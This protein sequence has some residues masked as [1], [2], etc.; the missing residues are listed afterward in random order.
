MT[1][2]INEKNGDREEIG[3]V[4]FLRTTEQLK[5]YKTPSNITQKLNN[6]LPR[7]RGQ[8]GILCNSKS[9]PLIELKDDDSKDVNSESNSNEPCTFYEALS[10]SNASTG[11]NHEAIISEL[12]APPTI[13][14]LPKILRSRKR[15]QKKAYYSLDSP[16]KQA[17]ND[18]QTI[19]RS[20][21][22]HMPTICSPLLQ[23]VEVNRYGKRA[24][25]YQNNAESSSKPK[26]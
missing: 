19:I 9:A 14:T 7:K 6:N 2:E 15:W 3:Y 10:N 13:S 26:R 5:T 12:A 11:K 16:L 23:S 25:N 24:S 20:D 21:I 1:D 8:F 4:E 17:S 18:K 22:L